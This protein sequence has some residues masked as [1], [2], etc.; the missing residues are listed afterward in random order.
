MAALRGVDVR[1]LLPAK[2]DHY[3]PYLSSFAFIDESEPA[4][5]K[6]Y[7]YEAG[8]LHQK[9]M[10]VDDDFAAVG[11]ANLDN[12]SFQ[13]NFEITIAIADKEFADQVETMLRVD[14]DRS[15]RV[16][17]GQLAHRPFWFR[18]AVRLA[19]LLAPVQ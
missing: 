1:I 8:F 9:V 15:C 10:L 18:L 2:P 12:R 7:R 4:G 19:R 17:P 13:L 3:S 6:F 16:T 5:V 11:T 14:F